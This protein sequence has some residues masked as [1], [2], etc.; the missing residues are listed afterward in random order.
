LR[1]STMLRNV[2][3]QIDE[4]AQIMARRT[5]IRTTTETVVILGDSGVPRCPVCGGVMIGLG[6]GHMLCG[7]TLSRWLESGAVHHCHLAGLP[8]LICLNSLLTCLQDNSPA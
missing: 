8:Y 3:M 5:I 1:L 6:Q 2:R 7:Q 4:S